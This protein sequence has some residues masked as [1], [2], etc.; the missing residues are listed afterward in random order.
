M[1]DLTTLATVKAAL[2]LVGSEQDALITSLISQV[3]QSIESFCNRSFAL[4]A[5]S[6][7]RHGTGS[8]T[9]LLRDYPAASIQAVVIN[10]TPL[11][12]SAWAL[13]DRCVVL[14]GYRFTP[15]RLNV[16]IDYLAGYLQIPADIELSCI[17]TVILCL[18]RLSHLD[19]ASKS[20]AGETVSYITA[21][22]P[23]SA[24]QRLNN[25]RAVAP[26]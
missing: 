3:S 12:T 11:P 5:R 15:G 14:Y 16:R 13:V 21:D 10:G 1:A 26:L 23:P 4:A 17:E 19:V 7:Y 25:Y 6:E 2:G 22:L 8:T 24:R 20:L 9:L 18:K